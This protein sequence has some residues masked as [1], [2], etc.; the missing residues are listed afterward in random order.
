MPAKWTTMMAL[1][2][3][4]NA[5]SIVAAEM[6]WLFKSTSAKTGLAPAVTMAEAEARKVREV[7]I[8]S[9]PAPIFIAFRATSKAKVP[10]PSA[11]AY[12]VPAHWANSF[13]NSRHSVPVQ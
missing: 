11:M 8:T 7:T 10:L 9:S 5:A 1:V 13:S 2:L 3:G 4:V 6:F 12:S